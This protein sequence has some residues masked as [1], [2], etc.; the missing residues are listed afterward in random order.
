MHLLKPYKGQLLITLILC[1]LILFL[2]FQDHIERSFSAGEINYPED[3]LGI[4]EL[5]EDLLTVPEGL[6]S[7]TLTSDRY[8][9]KKGTY[10]ISLSLNTPAAN[11]TLEICDALY[12]HPD[13][14]SGKVLASVRVPQNSSAPLRLTVSLEDY[15]T[16]IELRIHTEG[17]AQCSGFSLSSQKG[18]YRDPYIYACL[19]LFA[20]ALLL[21]LRIR[22]KPDPKSLALLIF[23]A[24]WTSL[25]LWVPCLLK[26]HDMF[27]HYG[28]LFNLSAD[29]TQGGLPV[30]LHGN[31][32][33]GFSYLSPVFYP[34]F[35][36]YPFA[37]LIRTGLS[38]IGC[39][40]LLLLCINIAT[41]GLTYYSFTRLFS[42]KT[43]GFVSAFLYTLSM[44]RI[45]N[46]YT[47][48]AV[49]EVLAT[50]FL[51]LLLLGMY[52]LF[53]GDSR[54]WHTAV[55]A[56]TAL[57]QSHLI[58]T[59]LAIGFSLLFGLWNI[60]RLREPKRL[61]HLILAAFSTLLLNLWFI[62]PLL[63]HM[64]Y[65]VAAFGDV[66]NLEGY[67]VY[68]LQLFLP[69]G[70]SPTGD[71]LGP[72][73]IAGEMPYSIGLSL[74]LGCVLFLLILLQKKE[75]DFS[76]KLGKACLL[77]GLLCL[78][79]SSSCFPWDILQRIGPLNRLAGNIQFAFRFLP[80][81]SLFL[82]L[83]ATVGIC[84]FF[85]TKHASRLLISFCGLLAIYNSGAYLTDFSE[86]AEPF[87]DWDTQM[88]HAMD[89]DGLYLI[90]DHGE[91][92]S[93][94]QMQGQ[95]V[96]FTPAD[97]V[98][99]SD[100]SRTRTTATFTYQKSSETDD[101]SY[102]DVPFNYYPLF[103]A[104]DSEGTPL[105]TS[106]GEL[107]RLRV[108]LPDSPRGSVTIHFELPTFYRLGDTLSLLTAL[109]FLLFLLYRQA[110]RPLR[111]A[112]KKL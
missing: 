46:L 111:P 9:L 76:I 7:V 106:H 66:R 86:Q 40:K 65:S 104:Y 69:T 105:E 84:R 57:L 58:S 67:S 103:Q 49:G 81:A 92:L 55:L 3:Y 99:L 23:A 19:L 51:P 74:I 109:L 30:R 68:P 85:S 91:Y 94:R 31:M 50:L 98:T 60:R 59:E 82:C 72:T 61:R 8:Y 16:C 17:A 43:Y 5:K 13:N 24:L 42:S 96:T 14:T 88:D 26:G 62:L 37:L 18:L 101:R 77:P 33:H 90:S 35:F 52:R 73:V 34:E 6:G 1:F 29:L 75:E 54:K 97:T 36:L 20:S 63:H 93:I 80:L 56:F 47:R 21:A 108:H 83:T 15:M 11:A 70:G 38:P 22:K 41:A 25:P 112:A 95:A 71:A 4:I 28:R 12:L 102:V 48:A 78:Y 10:E 45:V 53:L 27:F 2:P 107:N 32:Y 64:G 100:C 79:A 89:T 39:Y 110:A 44:Y 87:V